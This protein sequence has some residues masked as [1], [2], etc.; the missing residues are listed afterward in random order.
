MKFCLYWQVSG[1]KIELIKSPPTAWKASESGRL[2]GWA[3]DGEG[4][5]TIFSS[6]RLLLA[7]DF[8]A[9]GVILS[10]EKCIRSRTI[11]DRIFNE[12]E[13]LEFPAEKFQEIAQEMRSEDVP[14]KTIRFMDGE[15]K[16]ERSDS[17]DGGY[18]GHHD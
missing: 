3:E 18:A 6:S 4:K 12:G 2:T 15:W 1:D 14:L 17:L 7:R 11:P 8:P 10:L 13:Y 9:G 5:V 16:I